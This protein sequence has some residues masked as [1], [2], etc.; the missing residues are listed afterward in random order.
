MLSSWLLLA[1][2][3]TNAVFGKASQLLIPKE[4]SALKSPMHPHEV[5]DQP[6][7]QH[8]A[9]SDNQSS[10]HAQ[11]YLDN[12]GSATDIIFELSCPA[13]EDTAGLLPVFVAQMLTQSSQP[14]Q[15]HTTALTAM[16]SPL[17]CATDLQQG[18]EDSIAAL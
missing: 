16:Y 3:V 4:G 17:N 7:C 8:C 1:L 6:D 11:V 9:C 13:L 14:G 15:V 10:W 18:R 12:N 2:V 5:L